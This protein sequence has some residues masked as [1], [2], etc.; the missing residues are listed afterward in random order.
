M[1]LN[2]QLDPETCEPEPEPES[3]AGFFRCS[4]D[5]TL[6]PNTANKNLLLSEENRKVEFMIHPQ[7]YSDHPDRFINYFQVLSRESLTGRC[8]WEVEW[9][10]GA[11]VAVSYKNISRTG[12]QSLFGF[13][14]KSWCLRCFKDSFVFWHNNIK[15]SISGPGSS[16]IGVYLDHRAGLL[17]FYRVS[18]TRT[19]LHRVQTTF[20]QPLYAGLMFDTWWGRSS[21]EFCKLDKDH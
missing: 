4:C 9:R 2:D 13:N 20:T 15:T 10:G 8:Y 21:A 6:D 16:R 14:D 7:F 18:E 19:L 5:I 3:R 1:A 17:S 12:S 11:S